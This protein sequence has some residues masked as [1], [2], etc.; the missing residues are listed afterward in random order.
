[1]FVLIVDFLV[2]QNQDKANKK[3][4]SKT[5]TKAFNSLSQKLKKL[6]KENEK[7]VKKVEAKGLPEEWGVYDEDEDDDDDDDFDDD[8][9]DDDVEDKLQDSDDDD[10]QGMYITMVYVYGN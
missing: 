3:K 4:L 8:D 9:D 2:E 1:L 6:L 10:F 7:E 5:Q